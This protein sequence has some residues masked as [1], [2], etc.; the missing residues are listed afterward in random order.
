VLQ[1]RREPLLDLAAGV[2]KLV[3]IDAKKSGRRARFASRASNKF[4]FIGTSGA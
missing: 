4:F 3:R 1:E 2:E